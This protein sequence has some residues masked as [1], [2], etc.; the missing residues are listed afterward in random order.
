MIVVTET[1]LTSGILDAEITIPG[2]CIYRADRDESRTHGGVAI[3]VREDLSSNLET[4]HSNAVCETLVV[5]VKN[6]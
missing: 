4:V 5:K 1:H 2:Y 3:Y 6:S